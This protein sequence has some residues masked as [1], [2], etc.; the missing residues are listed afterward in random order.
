MADKTFE[1]F[2]PHEGEA[3]VEDVVGDIVTAMDRDL[4]GLINF[5]E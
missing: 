5:S 3:A 2:G 4:D 1:G